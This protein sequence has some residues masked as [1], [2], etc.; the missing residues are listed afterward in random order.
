MDLR[1]VDRLGINPHLASL[2]FAGIAVGFA[3]A[4]AI[5]AE[6]NTWLE[7]QCRMR[8]HDRLRGDSE[9]IT[10]GCR[11]ISLPCVHCPSSPF[12]A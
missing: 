8:Q 4:I 1:H 11:A 5:W 3:H 6:F 10:D 2:G 7:E 12:D 9:T